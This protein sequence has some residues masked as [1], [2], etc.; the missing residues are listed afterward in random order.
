MEKE[1]IRSDISEDLAKL[2]FQNMKISTFS[3]AQKRGLLSDKDTRWMIEHL[4]AYN[5]ILRQHCV[6][7]LQNL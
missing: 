7:T 4:K 6:N 2:N 3:F 5:Q 1:K